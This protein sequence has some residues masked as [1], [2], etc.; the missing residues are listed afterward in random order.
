[1]AFHAPSAGIGAAIVIV[2]FLIWRFF[3]SRRSFYTSLP[4]FQDNMTPEAGKALY[5]ATFKSLSDELDAKVKE[6]KELNNPDKEL[7]IWKEGRNILNE[8]SN[9]YDEF[10]LKKQKA[11]PQTEILHPNDQA[12]PPPKV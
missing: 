8:F 6:A 4:D 11:T 3:T 2:L 9:K 7:V 12:A 5:D 10:L 1:M